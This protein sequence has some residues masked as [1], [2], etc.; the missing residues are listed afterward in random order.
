MFI[1]VNRKQVIAALSDAVLCSSFRWL[2]SRVP[3][4]STYVTT[5]VAFQGVTVLDKDK[6]LEGGMKSA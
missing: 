6:W 2:C 1:F 3:A 5:E 4:I